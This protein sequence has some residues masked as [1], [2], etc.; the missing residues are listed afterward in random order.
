MGFTP[1]EGLVMGTRCGDLDPAILAHV[2]GRE[3]LGAP[4]VTALL[5]RHSGLLGLSGLSGDMRKLLEAEAAGHERARLAIEVFC[6]RLR[7]YLAAYVAVLGGV[8]GVAF[9]GGIGENAAPVR[10]RA[11]EGLQA[12]GL[13]L[14]PEK[15]RT[16]RGETDITGE[17]SQARVFVVPT[18]EELLIARDTFRIVT[19]AALA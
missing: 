1:L 8:D 16:A 12:L 2:A 9:A 18:N 15:N 11:F 14:D 6:H 17:G 5:N 4:E 19:G 10:A 13:R 7:K 3:E